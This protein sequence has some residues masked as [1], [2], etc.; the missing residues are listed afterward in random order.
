MA[1]FLSRI[2]QTPAARRAIEAARPP[3]RDVLTDRVRATLEPRRGVTDE[4]WTVADTILADTRAIEARAVHALARLDR[5]P[6]SGRLT[7]HAA[8]ARHPGV[9]AVFA[10]FG[11]PSCPSCAVGADETLEEAARGEGF[12]L[13]ALLSALRPLLTEN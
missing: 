5:E 8:H 13:E 6:L 12:E 7:V 10:Q 3:L 11:L 2:L 4:G 9:Q 1:R